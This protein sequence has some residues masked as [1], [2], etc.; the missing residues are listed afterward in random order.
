MP[1]IDAERKEL[2]RNSRV[3]AIIVTWKNIKLGD[4]CNWIEAVG[5]NKS[6]MCFGE[7]DIDSRCILEGCIIQGGSAIL[8]S[9]FGLDAEFKSKSIVKITDTVQF[10]RPKVI[11]GSEKTN[12]TV[13]LMVIL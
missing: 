9:D 6:A 2:T 11:E 1:T 7:F 12:L 8:H 4:D 13:S 5:I 3:Y 10:I